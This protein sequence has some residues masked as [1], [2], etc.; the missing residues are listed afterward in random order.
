MIEWNAMKL[1]KQVWSKQVVWHSDGWHLWLLD[2]D[3]VW[4][5]KGVFSTHTDTQCNI[6]V[7]LTGETLFIIAVIFEK[8]KQNKTES[9]RIAQELRFEL[10]LRALPLRKADFLQQ[11]HKASDQEE[12]FPPSLPA[13]WRLTSVCFTSSCA[14]PLLKRFGHLLRALPLVNGLPRRTSEIALPLNVCVAHNL[15]EKCAIYIFETNCTWSS[16]VVFFSRQNVTSCV[17]SV[18]RY[19]ALSFDLLVYKSGAAALVY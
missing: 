4:G 10:F 18:C 12:P 13:D 1:N 16:H 17:F 9:F 7:L 5:S 8:T 2:P 15:K 19:R 3:R 14:A 6:S 11:D